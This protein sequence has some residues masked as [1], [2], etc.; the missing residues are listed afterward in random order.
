MKNIS[1]RVHSIETLGTRDGPGLRCVFFMAGCNFR[2]QFCHNPDTFTHGGSKKVSLEEAREM[3]LTLQP[4]LRKQGGGIT[5]SGGEPTLQPDFVAGLFQVAH[6]LGLST[7]LDTNGS[8]LPSKRN[9]I[10]EETDLVLLDIKASDPALHRSLTHAPIDPTLEFGRVVAGRLAD[11]GKPGLV[12]RRVLL[13]GINDMPAEL[14][15]LAEY[16]KTLPVK[17][18]IELIPYHTL[19]MHKWKELGLRYEL[20]HLRP[21]TRSQILKASTFLTDRGFTIIQG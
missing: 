17:P 21:P 11:K 3:L 9:R 7:A 2:C 20:K 15:L 10:L 6:E 12:I 18:P 4:Y 5:A 13:P 1:G 8:C 16:L 19:G 14:G